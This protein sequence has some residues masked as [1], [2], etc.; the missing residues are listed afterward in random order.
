MTPPQF[1]DTIDWKEEGKNEKRKVLTAFIRILY[2]S[3][4]IPHFVSTVG[5]SKFP[6]PFYTLVAQCSKRA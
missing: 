2:L 1:P 5:L 4:R 3:Y 6:W